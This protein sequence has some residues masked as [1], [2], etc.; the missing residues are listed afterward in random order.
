MTIRPWV[1]ALLLIGLV[2]GCAPTAPVS[3]HVSISFRYSHFD[4]GLARVPAGVPVTITL[5]NG[6]PIEHEWIVGGP[7]VHALHRTGTEAFHEGRANEV[8]VPAFSTRTTTNEFD[9]PG[10]Y[11][12]TCHLPGHEAYGM[13]GTLRVV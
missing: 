10:N 12:F 6:D 11:A 13:T 7:E 9:Q 5:N 2:G 8:T 3:D 4:P 1:G